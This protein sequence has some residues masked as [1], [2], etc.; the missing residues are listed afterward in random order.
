MRAAA[1]QTVPRSGA[2]VRGRSA[3]SETPIPDGIPHESRRYPSMGLLAPGHHL[4]PRPRFQT[5]P[6]TSPDDAPQTTSC[7]R[8]HHLP[9]RPRAPGQRTRPSAVIAPPF[10]NREPLGAAASSFISCRRRV[11][12]IDGTRR[13]PRPPCRGRAHQLSSA[14][15]RLAFVAARRVSGIGVSRRPTPAPP[16]PRHAGGS[17]T[18][19]SGATGAVYRPV[20]VHGVIGRL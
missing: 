1:S 6:L 4:P 20:S 2:P 11:L 18:R 9:P 16:R 8:G 13:R 3:P 19:L 15:R 10:P 5:V 14:R 7:P 12:P 17:H